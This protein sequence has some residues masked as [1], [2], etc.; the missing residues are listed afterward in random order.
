MSGKTLSDQRA[1]GV[2]DWQFVLLRNDSVPESPDVVNLFLGSKLVKARRRDGNCGHHKPSVPRA[3]GS[4]N[5]QNESTTSRLTPAFPIAREGARASPA[6]A[7]YAL[8]F[9]LGDFPGAS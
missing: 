6:Q 5:R 8:F 7:A 2:G 3:C 1:L 4:D 9:H